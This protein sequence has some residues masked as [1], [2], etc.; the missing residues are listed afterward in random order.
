MTQSGWIA[1]ALLLGFALWLAMQN[2]LGAYWSILVGGSTGGTTPAAPQ[3]AAAQSSGMAPGMIG[4]GNP[5][6]PGGSGAPFVQ[7]GSATGTTLD[8]LL[9]NPWLAPFDP[10]QFHLFGPN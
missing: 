1:A 5:A 2:K 10:S 3:P 6:S 8:P 4:G 7:P 9:N